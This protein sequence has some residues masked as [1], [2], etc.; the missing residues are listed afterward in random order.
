M[1]RELL[2]GVS[3]RGGGFSFGV[4]RFIAAFVF[5]FFHCGP[6]SEKKTKRQRNKSG[7][8]SPHSKSRGLA[9]LPRYHTG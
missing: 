9:R 6:R 3:V 1:V 8:E 7:A 5:L 2:G 4:R